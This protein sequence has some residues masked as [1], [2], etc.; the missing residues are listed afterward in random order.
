MLGNVAASDFLSNI[1]TILLFIFELFGKNVFWHRTVGFLFHSAILLR[2]TLAMDLR[3]FKFTLCWSLSFILL[4][5]AWLLMNLVFWFSLNVVHFKSLSKGKQVIRCYVSRGP[6]SSEWFHII[7]SL[8]SFYGRCGSTQF[9]YILQLQD[10]S[11]GRWYC[12][13]KIM[14]AVKDCLTVEHIQRSLHTN[15]QRTNKH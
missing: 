11:T 15:T 14:M 1:W 10:I 8:L 9:Q 2:N 12:C 5:V 13:C 4:P 6:G 7:V 3:L